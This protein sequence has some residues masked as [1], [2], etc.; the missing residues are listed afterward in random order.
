MGDISEDHP[1]TVRYYGEEL[2]HQPW[3]RIRDHIHSSNNSYSASWL[4]LLPEETEK[5]KKKKSWSCVLRYKAFCYPHPTI[6]HLTN[7]TPLPP[8]FYFCAVIN[9]ARLCVTR[10]I[11]LSTDSTRGAPSSHFPF[12]HTA[13]SVLLLTPKITHNGLPRPQRPALHRF[14][15]LHPATKGSGRQLRPP[16]CLCIHLRLRR[17]LSRLPHKKGR[18]DQRGRARGVRARRALAAGTG[19]RAERAE[20]AGP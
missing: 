20:E 14:R 15:P 3:W 5:K 11:I 17:R 2:H 6:L 13:T 18:A 9:R 8:C 4:A 1:A 19:Q 10:L 12:S 7:L 16:G